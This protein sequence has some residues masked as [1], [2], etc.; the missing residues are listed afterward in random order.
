MAEGGS[1]QGE[2][3]TVAW[4]AAIIAALVIALANSGIDSVRSRED[5]RFH[6]HEKRIDELE[7][8]L[9]NLP[10]PSRAEANTPEA[11]G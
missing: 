9:R 5:Q 8:R 10:V 7:N 2:R 4:K 6:N 11:G 1:G 3:L